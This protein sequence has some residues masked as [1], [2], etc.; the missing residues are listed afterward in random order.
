MGSSDPEI[1]RSKVTLE[2]LMRKYDQQIKITDIGPLHDD[3]LIGLLS[4]NGWNA[5][6]K[7]HKQNIDSNSNLRAALSETLAALYIASQG[8]DKVRNSVRLRNPKKEIDAADGRCREGENQILVAEV[9]GRSTDDQDLKKSYEQ[10]C[11]LV[12]R[13]Q[14]QP[15]EI[16]ARLGIPT[17]HTTIRGIYISLGDAEKLKIQER[18]NVPLWGFDRFGEE[19]RKAQVPTRYRGL[20]RREHIAERGPLFGEDDWMMLDRRGEHFDDADLTADDPIDRQLL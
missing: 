12:V 10:F 13:L 20:L 11:D 3:E 18:N 6:R 1:V 14:Q 5:L 19:L 2:R 17:E 7:A 4:P 15:K 9:K 16:A 8:Y